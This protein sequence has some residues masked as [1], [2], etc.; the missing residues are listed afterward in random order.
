MIEVT[1]CRL[2]AAEAWWAAPTVWALAF[3]LA[4]AIPLERARQAIGRMN[5]TLGWLAQCVVCLSGQLAVLPALLVGRELG[6]WPAGLTCWGTT[7][8][9]A[10]LTEA[11]RIRLMEGPSSAFSQGTTPAN[12][13]CLACDGDLSGLAEHDVTV[14]VTTRRSR[15]Q[16]AHRHC[17]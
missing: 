8:A 3:G 6:S 13:R 17:P 9:G 7:W 12:A 16:Y 5:H 2:G 11:V 1:S 14:L 15:L 4:T 10:V